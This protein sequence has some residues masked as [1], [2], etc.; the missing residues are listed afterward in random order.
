M[1]NKTPLWT[2][3][4]KVQSGR[5]TEREVRQFFI[6]EPNPQQPFD[7]FVGINTE[8]VDVSNV[9]NLALLADPL[10]EGA[11]RS[12][13]L[14]NKRVK[15]I[16]RY[17]RK[18]P[19]IAEGD[20]WFRLPA[21]IYPRTLIDFLQQKYSIINLAH[22]GDT[23]ADMLLV[24]EFWP[25]LDTNPV[26]SDVLLFSAGGND[27]L[28]AGELWRFLNLFDVDHDKPSDAPYYVKQEFY[29]NLDVVIQNYESLLQQIQSRKNTKKTIVVGH[30]Y[31]YVIPQANGPWLGGP[32]L[33]Q[34]LDPVFRPKLCQAIVRILIDAFNSRLKILQ[35]NYP[36]NFRYVNLRGTIKPTEWFDELH[37][38]EV[39]A[40]KTAAKFAAVLESLPAS[41]TVAAPIA[42][43][44]PQLLRAA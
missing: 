6:V 29:E 32:L 2:V 34:G 28:G 7:L 30:G 27:I 26:A 43:F 22:W 3:V 16:S 9:E 4:Q 20:S 38:R 24:G 31:D 36:K 17:K 23:L 21:V 10:V 11:G 25:Y 18:S 37:P 35:N 8:R 40:R 15:R 42:V 12:L 13:D 19:I 33:R 39:G 44:H 14:R 41:G 1:P 5:I